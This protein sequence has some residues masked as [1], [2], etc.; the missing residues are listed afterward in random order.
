[1]PWPWSDAWRICSSSI[2]NQ[3]DWGAPLELLGRQEPC[4]EIGVLDTPARDRATGDFVAIELKRNLADDEVIGQL[5]R[6]MG[7]LKEHRAAALA[8]ENVR[9]F[10]YELG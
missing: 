6:Y 4:G 2:A 3:L 5:S 8:H 9:L 7:W 10:T 1:M